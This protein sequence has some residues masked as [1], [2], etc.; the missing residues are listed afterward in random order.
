MIVKKKPTRNLKLEELCAFETST[1]N[2]LAERLSELNFPSSPSKSA[3]LFSDWFWQTCV[4][5]NSICK[6]RISSDIPLERSYANYLMDAVLDEYD[7]I[8]GHNHRINLQLFLDNR[9]AIGTNLLK[10]EISSNRFEISKKNRALAIAI[11]ID[12]NCKKILNIDNSVAT[13][14]EY[15]KACNTAYVDILKSRMVLVCASI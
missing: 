2:F 3:L 6:F 15:E 5:L 10:F 13:Y 9:Q 7:S 11:S 1:L 8:C 14:S 4:A 12:K